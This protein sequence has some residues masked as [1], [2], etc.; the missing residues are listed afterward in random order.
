MSDTFD[1]TW[2]P[3]SRI[4]YQQAGNRNYYQ[5]DADA[6]LEKHLVTDRPIG[7]MFSPVYSPD[8]LKIA[9]QWNRRPKR[10]IWLIDMANHRETLVHATGAA[11]AMPIAWS[12]DGRSVYVIEGKNLN[13]R[14]QTPP[15]GETI[16]EARIVRMLV[17]GDEVKTVVDLPFE[18]IGGVSMTPNGRRFICVVYSSRSDVWVVDNFDASP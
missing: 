16:T 18:E 8:G 1:L 14:G 9:V 4:L 7:W 2:A 5:L 12:A 11:S 6:R 10:G 17:N 13:S 3:G 15:L